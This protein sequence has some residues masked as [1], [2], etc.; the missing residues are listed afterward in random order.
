M[1][2]EYAKAALSAVLLVT[3]ATSA[4][5]SSVALEPGPGS[6]LVQSAC[7]ICHSVDYIVMNSPF[8]DRA[9]WTRTVDK[10]VHV[11]G[12]PLS[13]EDAAKVVDYLEQY[14]GKAKTPS[15]RQ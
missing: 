3:T 1:S 9:G 6:E 13:P 4:D 10:M 7:A 14:Y 15:E 12:A 5:E 2:H 8:Q 11:M